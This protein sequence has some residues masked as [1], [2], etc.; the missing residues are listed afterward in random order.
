M[1]CI[2]IQSKMRLWNIRIFIRSTSVN[3]SRL[4]IHPTRNLKWDNVLTSLRKLRNQQDCTV[5][6]PAEKREETIKIRVVR[7]KVGMYNASCQIHIQ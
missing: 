7:V 6:L 1:N 2:A 4:S 3:N 5:H